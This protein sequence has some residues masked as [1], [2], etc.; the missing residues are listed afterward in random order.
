MNCKNTKNIAIFSLVTLLTVASF[1]ISNVYAEEN[2]KD[3]T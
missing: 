2:K 1:E 3:T